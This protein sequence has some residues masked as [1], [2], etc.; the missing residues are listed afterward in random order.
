MSPEKDSG[1]L[2]WCFWV[3]SSDDLVLPGDGSGLAVEVLFQVVLLSLSDCLVL[4]PDQVDVARLLEQSGLSCSRC[5]LGL[6]SMLGNVCASGYD[7]C[8]SRV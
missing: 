5:L 1:F 6:G 3:F 4:P 8:S 2:F 7:A